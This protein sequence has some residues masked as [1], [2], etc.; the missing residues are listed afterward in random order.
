MILD[1]LVRDFKGLFARDSRA[2][3]ALWFDAKAEFRGILPEV[4]RQFAEEG[5]ILL[6]FDKEQHHG[7]LWLKWATEVGPGA[8]K[9]VV[10]WLP[11]P[12]KALVSGTDD[13]THL[14]CLLEYT[15]EGLVWLIES[16]PP[17]LFRFLRAHGVPLPTKRAEQDSLWRGGPESPLA[18]YVRTYLT[19]DEAFW[20]S[21]PLTLTLIQESIV[22]NVEERLLQLLADPQREWDALQQMGIAEEFRAQVETRYA[23][24]QKLAA[25]PQDW[26]RAFV[27]SLV[28]LEILE[29]TGGPEDF[30]F[31][32][33]LPSPPRREALR[34]LLRRWMSHRDHLETYRRWALE[35][36]RTI[37]LVAWARTKEGHPQAL[38]SLVK[39]RW[40]RFLEGL[41]GQGA[42]EE[43]LQR[44]L[45]AHKAS[46]LQEAKG[47]WASGTKDLAGWAL[48]AGLAELVERILTTV[49][50]ASQMKTPAKIV[51]AY[52][53]KW[54]QIDLAHWHLLA[55]A[56]RAE[57]MELLASIADRFYVKYLDAVSRA[58]YDAFRDE[59]RWPPEGCKPI[60]ELTKE[61][62]NPPE[63]R[64]AILVVDALR[65]DL[66]AAL[67]ERLGEGTLEA[68]LANV[69]SETYVGMTSLLPTPDARLEVAEGKP[70]LLSQAAGGD[71]SY[72]AYRWKLLEAAGAAC[73]GQDRKGAL[74]DEIRH[75]RELS[76][77][78]KEP[79]QLLVLFDR[80]VDELGHSTGYELIRHFE[81]L[82]GEL[83]RA[84]RKLRAWGYAEV[85]V[86]TDHGFVLLR[87]D[88]NI[89]PIE[90]DKSMFEVLTARSGL[91]RAGE[92]ATT[93][94]VPFPLDP[95]WSV[96]L[97]PGLRSFSAPGR[98]FH[99]GATLQEVVIPHLCFTAPKSRQR[100]RVHVQLPQVKIATLTV[101]V[102]LIPERPASVGL[103]DEE[104]E[105]TRVRVFLGSP[106]APRSNEKTIEIDAQMTEIIPV[107]LFLHREPPTPEGTQIPLH[108]TDVATGEAYATGLFVRAARDL[109]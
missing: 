74:R 5:I 59:K 56:W 109:E 39:D 45:Q 44:Y 79:P 88:A 63:T 40:D 75:L 30:P 82:L 105:S 60:A 21:R 55:A 16:K 50:E 91:L 46:I 93:A 65:F 85:H 71:L 10:I 61:L 53:S 17:T 98:Y 2:R 73:L 14:D 97:P 27:A 99:G 31:A 19:R 81:E 106:E 36:E 100:M 68:Y 104:P 87:S 62:Y 96:A 29:S 92:R 69:P 28:L 3:V 52:A 43:A 89:Q 32:S 80:D 90:V 83:E 72:R 38:R 57:E 48:A 22:G 64:R 20:T 18:K 13:G 77:P 11:Y 94:T 84:I 58:F 78:P 103:F 4:E 12:Q 66:A 35:L 47:F 9:K 26:A 33:K 107:T 1:W 8:E 49:E 95:S 41:R 34:E 54:H 42:S 25:D 23:E 70:K 76:E 7:A 102:E 67:C 15:Y 51:E 108:V 86:V 101:K 24:T 37:D 6:A